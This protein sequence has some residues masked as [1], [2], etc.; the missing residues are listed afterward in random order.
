M[1]GKC[2]FNSCCLFGFNYR[3]NIWLK[4]VRTCRTSK[5]CKRVVTRCRRIKLINNCYKSRCLTIRY[6]SKNKIVSKKMS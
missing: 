1:I 3:K 5:V 6:N 4:R 2:K